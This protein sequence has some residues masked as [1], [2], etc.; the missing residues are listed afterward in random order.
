V[1]SAPHRDPIRRA[2][3]WV[4][5]SWPAD[6]V[7]THSA[8]TAA[9][10]FEHEWDTQGQAAL[11]IEPQARDVEP[12]FEWL[13]S[14]RD[15]RNFDPAPPVTALIAPIVDGDGALLAARSKEHIDMIVATFARTFAR[16]TIADRILFCGA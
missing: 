9:Q 2:V 6:L 14:A 3:D 13:R 4:T 5:T 15:W 11:V 12:A 7:V 8:A 10:L 16:A 1:I